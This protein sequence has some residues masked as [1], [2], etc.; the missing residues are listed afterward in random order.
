[1]PSVGYNIWRKEEENLLSMWGEKASG[2]SWLHAHAGR[3]FSKQSRCISIPSTILSVIASGAIFSTLNS[4][5]DSDYIIKVCIGML[6]IVASIFS[7]LQSVL[8]YSELSEQHKG[9]SSLFSSFNR[10]ISAELTLPHSDRTNPKDFLRLSRIQFDKLIESSPDIPLNIINKF[11][12]KFKN[13]DIAKPDITNGIHKI[14]TYDER[15]SNKTDYIVMKSFYSW[16]LNSLNKDNNIQIPTT[17]EFNYNKSSPNIIEMK[18]QLQKEIGSYKQKTNNI[19]T[20]ITK[21]NYHN[22]TIV[23]SQSDEHTDEDIDS[24]S[25]EHTGEDI[26]YKPVNIIVNK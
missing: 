7:T 23:D 18:S 10:N 3:Q 20:N 25:D 2:F 9:A 8:N 14:I 4:C 17:D 19:T 12:D 11:N 6:N 22:N 26:D 5:D 13:I 21:M 1:M 16:A 15:C 24:P